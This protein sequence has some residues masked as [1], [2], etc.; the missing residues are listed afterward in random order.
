[1]VKQLRILC[2][3][4]APLHRAVTLVLLVS[5]PAFGSNTVCRSAGPTEV[6]Y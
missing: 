2:F 6:S 1:V 4:T 5:Q 3:L